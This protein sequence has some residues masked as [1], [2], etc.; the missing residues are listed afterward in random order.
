MSNGSFIKWLGNRI[1]LRSRIW[2]LVPK[3]EFTDIFP[4][5]E[6]DLGGYR[7][8]F[9]GN[10]LNA[11][12][13]NRD[14][15]PL[16]SGKVYNQDIPTGLH[17]A[18]IHIYSPLHKIPMADGFFDA[19]ICNAVLEH[20]ENPEEV[21]EEFKRVCKPGGYLILCIPFLQPEHKDP[22]DFQR[23]TVDGLRRLIERHDFAVLKID[24]VHS[25]YSTLGWIFYLWLN[26]R[27]TFRHF[28]YKWIF[29]PYLRRKC[30]TSKFQVPALASAH[31][32]VARRK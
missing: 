27:N 4:P 12:A 30:R 23:Y 31:C 9:Q 29:Y 1:W 24:I 28:I 26:S 10:V 25:V 6:N 3:L 18:N 21:M 17:N 8:Y 7:E 14:L 13:G 20:V 22:T 5:I 2:R 32:A 11:G 16:V 15:S 19:I